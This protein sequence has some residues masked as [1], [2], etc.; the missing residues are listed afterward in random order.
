MVG[1]YDQAVESARAEFFNP[2]T[3]TEALISEEDAIRLAL[4][5]AGV[6][7]LLER[8]RVAEQTIEQLRGLLTGDEENWRHERDAEEALARWDVVGTPEAG[9]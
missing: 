3:R 6:P 5:A 7:V 8:L 2:R 9:K 4:D 1:S